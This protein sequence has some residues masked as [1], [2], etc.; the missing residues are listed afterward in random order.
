MFCSTRLQ[1]SGVVLFQS[2]EEAWFWAMAIL[3]ARHD[4]CGMAWR[5]TMV[6]RPCD[7]E[8]VFNCLNRLYRARKLE[9]LHVRVLLGWGER[10]AAPGDAG[11]H[12]PREARLWQQAMAE[13]EWSLRKKRIVG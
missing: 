4:G 9:L 7:P 2:S 10:Q 1:P 6:L 12:R 11:L 3:L 13:L 8:D 5:P